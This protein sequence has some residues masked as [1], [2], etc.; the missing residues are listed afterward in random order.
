M[1]PFLADLDPT[2][3]TGRI[4]LNA[5]SDQYTVTWCTVRG[6]DVARS[7]TVQ[8]TLLPNGNIEMIYGSTINLGDAIVGLSPGRTGTFATVTEHSGQTAGDPRRGDG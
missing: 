6:F 4:F 1:S 8:A 3:G 5:A 2:T 7:V